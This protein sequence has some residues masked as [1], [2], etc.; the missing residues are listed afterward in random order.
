MKT[1][2]VIRCNLILVLGI[3][4]IVSCQKLNLS[5][6]LAGFDPEGNLPS[7]EISLTGP[8]AAAGERIMDMS[9]AKVYTLE[10]A[11][12]VP[13]MA[14]FILLYS[15]T[16]GMNLVSP[17]DMERLNGW[18]PGKTINETWLLKNTTYFIRLEASA[19]HQKVYNEIKRSEDLK[20]A[21][22]NAK[23]LVKTQ[24]NYN[25][26]EHGPTV[27]VRD[28]AVGD[29]LFIKTEKEAYGVARVNGITTGNSGSLALSFKLDIR[30]TVG[31]SP[32]DA[33]EKIDMYETLVDRPGS[34]N[35]KRFLDI[36]TGT[37]Y[38][39]DVSVPL[40]LQAIGN[41]EK[42]DL[43]FGRSA[44]SGLFNLISMDNNERLDLFSM[45]KEVIR[46]W[47]V[48]NESSII[49]L[50][51]SAFTDSL[52]LH[53]YT[54]SKLHGAYAKALEKVVQQDNYNVDIHGAGGHISEIEMGDLFFV[55][56]ESKKVLAMVKVVSSTLGTAGS[57]GLSVKVDNSEKIEILPSPG[58]LKAGELTFGGYSASG[59][60]GATFLVDLATI[61]RQ[62]VATAIPGNID[63]ISMWSGGGYAN[64][65]PPGAPDGTLNLWGGSKPM[66]EWPQ[67]N[68]G[69][70]MHILGATSAEL[71]AFDNLM[72]RDQLIQA[73]EST[74]L[75][76]NITSRPDYTVSIN[77]PSTRIQ[78][79]DAGSIVYYKSTSEGRNLYAAMKII[80]VTLTGTISGREVIVMQV[81]SNLLEE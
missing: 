16:T 81:K 13:E 51:A 32:I 33:S 10:N 45:G 46:D 79:M 29:I 52:F 58:M 9:T 22:E 48:K 17:I 24:E 70:Y 47:L 18:A 71:T 64:F 61:S 77:G 73:F 53:T 27:S 74:Q 12:L 80:S 66:L 6:D 55:K 39:R 30:N 37:T 3:L 42:V 49:K 25:E 67:R 50:D 20:P 68:E 65:F 63:L 31:V 35:G 11:T 4:T 14:D 8:G 78:K 7:L 19:E 44:S 36:T 72:T 43:F 59:P 34:N 38:I 54:K 2:Q 23:V 15:T 41:Q 1:L 28:L 75:G 69:V 5:N 26:K 60:E 21:Y 62:T 56:S 40:E 57:L 76:M